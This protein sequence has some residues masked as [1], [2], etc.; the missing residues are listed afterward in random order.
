MLADED[1]LVA[2][3][4]PPTCDCQNQPNTSTA[5]ECKKAWFIAVRV[6][7]VS[8]QQCLHKA[9]SKLVHMS[10]GGFSVVHA[11]PL[12]VALFFYMIP[13][14]SEKQP[15]HTCDKLWINSQ[16]SLLTPPAS[17]N[18]WHSQSWAVALSG[19]WLGLQCAT[20]IELRSRFLSLGTARK[21]END[22]F[23]QTDIEIPRI[24]AL[25]TENWKFRFSRCS[26]CK[27]TWDWWYLLVWFQW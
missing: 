18:V 22:L 5:E 2:W 23:R 10:L 27:M 19:G 15:S 16:V 26:F 25:R 9:Y 7:H 21:S 1:K 20:S 3:P 4:K 13:E 6:Y 8:A 12:S 24:N 17:V 11:K 14:C